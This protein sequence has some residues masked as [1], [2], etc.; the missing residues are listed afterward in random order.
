M[1]LL[2]L[3]CKK[4]IEANAIRNFDENHVRAILCFSKHPALDLNQASMLLDLSLP[5]TKRT[6][7]RLS[8]LN[9][10]HIADELYEMPE[11][12]E[13]MENLLKNCKGFL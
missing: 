10:I 9:V 6:L 12:F 7:E 8:R 1:E 13:S 3:A 4:L 5:E 2:K 11:V